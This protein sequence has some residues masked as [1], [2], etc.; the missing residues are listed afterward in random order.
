MVTLFRGILDNI[1]L[2][3]L[4]VLLTDAI[5]FSL[6]LASVDNYFIG[7]RVQVLFLVYGILH[8]LVFILFLIRLR[9]DYRRSIN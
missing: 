4:A 7:Q 6:I 2:V 5:L 9:R 3:I 1:T 8:L